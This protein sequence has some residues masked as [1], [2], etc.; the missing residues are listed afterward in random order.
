MKF[1]FLVTICVFIFISSFCIAQ[2]N[3]LDLFDSLAT[4][5]YKA[6]FIDINGDTLTNEK[7]VLQ[8][9]G[10]AW[11]VQK[12]QILANYT[13]FPDSIAYFFRDPR[14]KETQYIHINSESRSG[15]VETDSS[16]WIHP[17]RDNQYLYTEV[18]PFPN[19]KKN[20]LIVGSEWSGG[21]TFIMT[22]W[23]KFRGRLKSTYH[24][25]NMIE[26][27]FDN[28]RLSECW[29]IDATGIHNK[30]GTST[31]NIVYHKK[32]GFLEMN[33]VFYNGAKIQFTLEEVTKL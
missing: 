7:V 19:V 4:Y 9:T 2:S 8:S 14:F 27:E 22:G 12:T 18:A 30:L 3:K 24:V 25:S 11:D 1:N 32:Y 29:V 6:L 17:F 26:K 10:Q 23:G 21:I 28:Q 20:K 16:V 33:Y 15:V 13:Y 31:L 5:Q